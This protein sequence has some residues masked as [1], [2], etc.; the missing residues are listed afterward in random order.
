MDVQAH[1]TTPG[2]LVEGGQLLVMQVPEP[3]AFGLL[4][5]STR[6]CWPAPRRAARGSR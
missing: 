3:S 6:R 1:Y 5:V 4:A 2:E